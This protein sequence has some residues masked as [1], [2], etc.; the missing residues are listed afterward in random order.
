MKKDILEL[1]RT[2]IDIIYQNVIQP[3]PQNAKGT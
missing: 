1:I 2:D 3:A